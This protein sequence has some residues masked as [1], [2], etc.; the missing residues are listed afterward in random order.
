M[1]TK[2]LRKLGFSQ[3]KPTIAGIYFIA[4]HPISCGMIA[5]YRPK[6]ISEGW[7]LANIYFKN[8]S[9]PNSYDSRT[10]DGLW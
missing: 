3:K 10:Q 5:E 2:E 4:A 1:N 9:W 8:D 6:R 7:D